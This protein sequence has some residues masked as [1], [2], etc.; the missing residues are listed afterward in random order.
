MNKSFILSGVV[1]TIFLLNGCGKK[2]PQSSAPFESE[3]VA[4]D[5]NRT[6]NNEVASVPQSAAGQPQVELNSTT[7]TAVSPATG[8][9]NP[10]A[11]PTNQ[12]IQQSLK[13]A[14]LY[15]GTIDG[16][17]GP[18]TKKAIREFQE[19]NNLNADGKVGPRTWAKLGPYLH[20]QN[21]AAPEP[22]ANSQGNSD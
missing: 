5:M 2:A 22:A 4:E 14:G 20:Q 18:R 1:V 12:E 8:V 9:V 19:Q 3:E 16:V 17:I 13:N 7:V 21:A 6:L 11:N 15:A 10:S